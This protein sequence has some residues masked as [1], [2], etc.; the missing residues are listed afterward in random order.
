[1]TGPTLTRIW[2]ALLL[3]PLFALGALTVGYALATPACERSM[4]WALHLSFVAFLLLSLG[5]TVL[6]WRALDAARRE[7]LP[8]IA[9]GTGAFFSAVIA[10]QWVAVFM[11]SPCMD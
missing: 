4:A 7:F 11:I 5:A 1:M 3:A 2:P 10:A 8:L 6:A 9:T